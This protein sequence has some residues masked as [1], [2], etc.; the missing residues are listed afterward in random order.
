MAVSAQAVREYLDL[1]P[2][3]FGLQERAGV[4]RG[5]LINLLYRRVQ[6]LELGLSL[7]VKGTVMRLFYQVRL[8]GTLRNPLSL[9]SVLSVPVF[10]MTLL[11]ATAQTS[12]GQ[13]EQ[14]AVEPASLQKGSQADSA[15]GDDRNAHHAEEIKE[16]DVASLVREAN[17]NG[18]AMLRRMLEY[19]YSLKKIRRVLNGDGKPMSERVDTFEAYPVRGQHVLIQ[20][21]SDGAQLPVSHV[22]E[23]RRRAGQNLVRAENEAKKEEGRAESPADEIRGYL[24]AGISGIHRSKY[25]SV[26]IDISEILRTCEF[27]APRAAWFGDREM[28]LL[29]FRPRPDYNFPSNKK[30]I[31]R[32]AGAVWIDASDKVVARLEARTMPDPLDTRPDPGPVLIYEQARQPSGA[33]F[34]TLIRLNT[35]GDESL[36]NGLNWDVIF[37]LSEFRHFTSSAEEVK[38][39]DPDK[40]KPHN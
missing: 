21:T 20:L 28:I 3:H 16:A 9:F 6:R 4:R 39:K 38:I 36:A 25:A 8:D 33:W 7:W 40:S 14:K 19:T 17:S 27:V 37:E 24:A 11:A 31:S 10:M 29:S 2:G 15:A 5:G 18:A 13:S 34:P 26:T 30:Y 23:E 12:A 22:A 32:L 35:R 1:L